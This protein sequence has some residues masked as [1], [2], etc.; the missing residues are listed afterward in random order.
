VVFLDSCLL[1]VNAFRL[2]FNTSERNICCDLERS[3]PLG[4]LGPSKAW[5]DVFRLFPI[6]A[7][8]PAS[9][10]MILLTPRGLT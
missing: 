9:K 5:V 7:R 2:V 1:G 10:F 3:G 8:C 4:L 6:M